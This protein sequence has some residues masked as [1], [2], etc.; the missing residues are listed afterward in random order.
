MIVVAGSVPIKPDKIGE[1][2]TAAAAVCAATRA[3]KG[4][5]GYDFSLDMENPTVMRIFEQWES[6]ADLDAH[7]GQPH[8]QAFLG[9][10]GELAA[11]ASE[12]KRYVVAAVEPL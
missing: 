8:T 6:A 3:E 12:V 1:L 11:G 7:L 5:I 9:K 2:R 4:C 10:L